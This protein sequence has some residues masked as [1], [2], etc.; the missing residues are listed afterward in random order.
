LY[1]FTKLFTKLKKI[2]MKNIF[3]YLFAFC[4]LFTACKK[5]IDETTITDVPGPTTTTTE[6]I[7]FLVQ[8]TQKQPLADATVFIDGKAFKTDANGN[9]GIKDLVVEANGKA[10]SAQKAGYFTGYQRV[11]KDSKS[12]TITMAPK[13]DCFSFENSDGI[14]T[15]I[16]SFIGTGLTIP[17][18]AFEKN[19]GT[20]YSGTVTICY[21]RVKKDTTFFNDLV[22]SSFSTAV[23]TG[24]PY[25]V[26]P[27]GAFMIEATDN[28]GAYLKLKT[29]KKISTKLRAYDPF[30]SLY[31]DESPALYLD[32]DNGNVWKEEGKMTKQN[33]GIEYTFD[34]IKVNT[35]WTSSSDIDIILLEGKLMDKDNKP[36]KNYT[37][38]TQNNET[39]KI[40]YSSSTDDGSFSAFAIAGKAS[41]ISVFCGGVSSSNT[42]I[43]QTVNI[44]AK[45]KNE[46]IGDI[47]VGGVT[48]IKGKV[49][50]CNNNPVTSGTIGIKETFDNIKIEA[51]G[52]FRYNVTCENTNGNTITVTSFANGLAS[53]DKIITIDA[54]K[55]TDVGNFVL[56]NSTAKSQIFIQYDSKKYYFD[57]DVTL[58]NDPSYIDLTSQKVDADG[59]R[60]VSISID[61]PIVLNQPKKLNQLLMVGQDQ[62]AGSIKEWID[63]DDCFTATIIKYSTTE[64]QG[65]LT[66]TNKD[67]KSVTGTFYYKK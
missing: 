2:K 19:D 5:E 51:D 33:N 58:F 34:V 48:I 6:S 8:N 57:Q 24:K 54:G 41:T 15:K 44:P 16:T 31:P 64:V 50:D 37:L 30:Y 32:S 12:L 59:Y 42:S 62:A 43:L 56:C 36:L 25:R 4:L 20:P 21:M 17:T 22:A 47:V 60:I 13:K 18:N 28:N 9:V 10:A 49:V 3:L 7:T 38:S 67:G 40:Y 27:F 39:G 45:T 65:T 29:G 1:Y 55:I 66:G 61:K 14:T 46:T 11:L 63:C 53:A 35:L 26:S 52:T 23:S